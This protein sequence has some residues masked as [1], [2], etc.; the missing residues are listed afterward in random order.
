MF[1]MA[2]NYL[3]LTVRTAWYKFS[4]DVL[5]ECQKSPAGAEHLSVLDCPPYP[6]CDF[7]VWSL[8]TSGIAR[9]LTE[10]IHMF[11]TVLCVFRSYWRLWNRLRY[12]EVFLHGWSRGKAAFYAT[13][14]SKEDLCMIF[15]FFFFRWRYIASSDLTS[16]MT[17][18]HY[19]LDCA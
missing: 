9:F 7:A 10:I 1:R 5:G 8:V 6:H 17:F 12:Q 15:F 14:V 16:S 19:S 11:L 2:D 18:R 4:A 3:Y 13:G